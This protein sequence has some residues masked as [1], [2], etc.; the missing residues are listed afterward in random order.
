MHPVYQSSS[1]YNTTPTLTDSGDFQAL[2]TEW[3]KCHGLTV[4]D[5]ITGSLAMT[6]STP[7]SNALFLSQDYTFMP[8]I[9]MDIPLANLDMAITQPEMSIPTSVDS[10]EFGFCVDTQALSTTVKTEPSISNDCLRRRNAVFVPRIISE[11]VMKSF[12]VEPTNH[13][14]ESVS[15]AERLQPPSTRIKQSSSKTK[16]SKGNSRS[17]DSHVNSILKNWTDEHMNN[18]YASPQEKKRLMKETGLSKM[19]LKNW[20]CNVR[21]RKYPHTIKRTKSVQRPTRASQVHHY[22]PF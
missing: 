1:S 8:N 13:S 16:P 20:F 15:Y 5:F 3:L 22:T 21:R 11:A 9:S 19:Q 14:F 10:S 12:K 17:Y 2:P 4:P 6:V 7:A 18:L